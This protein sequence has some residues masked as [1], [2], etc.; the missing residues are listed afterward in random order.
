[1]ASAATP[2]IS[3][4]GV[5]KSFGAVRA[6]RG[7]DLACHA[8]EC[9]GL[10]GHNGAGKSTLM[11]LLAGVFP[12]EGRIEVDGKDIA[13]RYSVATAQA[14]GIRCVFQELSLCPNLTVAENAR[15]MHASLRGFG[16]RKRAGKLILDKLDEV[17]PGH[18]I[19][20]SDIVGDLPIARRQM[21]EI[22]RAFS[23]TTAPARLVI[24]D[25][26]TSSLDAHLAS[27]LLAYVRSF[28]AKGGCVVLISHLLGEILA[29]GDRVVVMKDGKVV[30]ER[31]AADFNRTSLVAAMGSVAHDEGA[32]AATADTKR[33]ET[34][35]RVRV[36]ADRQAGGPELIAH[37]GEIV[38]LAGLG[39]QGQSEMLIRIFD[40]AGKN[41]RNV[42]VV[43]GVALVA[44]DRQTDGV[45]PLWSIAEN[46][47]ISS[48]RRMR[49]GP[50]IDGAATEAM[51]E[52]WKQRIGIRTPD[53]NNP[54][55]SLSGG[56]QQKALFARALGSD[57]QTVLMDDPMRGVDIG[58]KQEVYG[59]IRA[60]AEAGRTFLW[61]TTEM[62]ELKHCDHVYVFRD[63]HI[64]AELS[65]SELTEEKVLH[66]SFAEVA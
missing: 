62:D 16:W 41:A 60:E 59:M 26:P 10:V 20:A 35:P 44:G 8:G 50:L 56:N 21:V 43:G 52:D 14:H 32:N 12:A 11:N 28:V 49:R 30:V 46:I 24:L 58:T 65:R 39:G 45:F 64:V 51:A 42:T 37:Q 36:A 27:Q 22:A 7:V 3:L 40:A 13:S 54:I 61:Y 63:H 31:P 29:A 55:L 4:N 66:A 2:I 1:M 9:I 48:L 47:T 19:S 15:I 5:E 34:E 18:G 25:E 38:G 17:F 6:L 33:S 57:A 53:M 23:V